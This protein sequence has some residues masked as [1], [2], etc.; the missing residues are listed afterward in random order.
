MSDTTKIPPT[1][2]Y[3]RTKRDDI[4]ALAQKYGA[5]NVRVFGSVARGDATPESDVD[6]LVTFREGTSLYEVSGLWQDLQDLLKCSVDLVTDDHHP[7]RERFLRRI[8]KDTV[9]L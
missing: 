1:L 6:L 9:I 3:L 5:S 4:L 8:L 7:R 2:K